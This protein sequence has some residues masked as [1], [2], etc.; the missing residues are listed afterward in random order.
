M[1]AAHAHYRVTTD[2]AVAVSAL[3]DVARPLAEGEC[4]PVMITA[5]EHLAAIGAAG[6]AAHAIARAV[7]D[8]PRRLS[9][10]G[11]RHVCGE[12]E[13]LRTAAAALLP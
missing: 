12:D 6:E 7:L 3:T 10:F 5:L 4:L 9:H 8:S 13:R 1:E 2:P 11:G